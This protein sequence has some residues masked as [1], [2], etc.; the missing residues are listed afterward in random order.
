MAVG[1]RNGQI[2]MQNCN[3]NACSFNSTKSSYAGEGEYL[4][5][6]LNG[7]SCCCMRAIIKAATTAA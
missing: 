4:S 2:Q 5:A 3:N 6:Q 7:G 1:Q